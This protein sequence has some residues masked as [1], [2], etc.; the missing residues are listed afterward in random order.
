MAAGRS[1]A[2]SVRREVRIAAPI[3]ILCALS[4]AAGAAGCARIGDFERPIPSFFH[5]E[6]LPVAGAYAAQHRGEPVSSA[7]LTEDE[8]TLRDLAYAIIAPPVTKQRWFLTITDLRT[9]RMLPNNEPPFDVEKYA[10]SIIDTAY[11]SANGRYSRLIDDIRAD[12]L[13]VTPFFTVAARVVEMDTARERSLGG[14]ARLT[15]GEQET[16][17]ARVAENRML[18]GWVYRRFGERSRGYKYALERLFLKTPA[19]ISVDAERAL[20]AFDE[21]LAKIPVLTAPV[22]YFPGNNNGPE[23]FKD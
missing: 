4:I 19:P 13:R 9:S 8:R 15:A 10:S 7:P 2:P 18:I 16:A 1:G 23:Y 5:N 6:M 21:R 17:M 12:S 3:K 14:I 20:R 22:A 11:R